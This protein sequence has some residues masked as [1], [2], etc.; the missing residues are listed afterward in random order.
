MQYTT[1]AMRSNVRASI[2]S[3]LARMLDWRLDGKEQV[4]RGVGVDMLKPHVA[5]AEQGKVDM[6][7]SEVK[8]LSML[9]MS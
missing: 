9:K 5:G 4:G 2:I 3:I 6:F 8:D 1:T 7:L